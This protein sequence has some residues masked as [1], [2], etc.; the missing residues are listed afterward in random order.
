ME[1]WPLF[2]VI[3]FVSLKFNYCQYELLSPSSKKKFGKP[4]GWLAVSYLTC[5]TTSVQ[6][7]FSFQ[8][9]NLIRKC[10]P[11]WSFRLWC[12]VELWGLLLENARID[13]FDTNS[14]YSLARMMW[15]VNNLEIFLGV[16][17]FLNGCAKA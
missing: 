1:L 3:L 13:S 17:E 16:I 6:K 10:L 7:R 4:P 15:V 9:L 14:L 2:I 5:D 11:F 8:P 12:I